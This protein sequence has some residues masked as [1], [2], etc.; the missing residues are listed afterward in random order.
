MTADRFFLEICP[1]GPGDRIFQFPA[2]YVH[3]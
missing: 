2:A 3:S 1:S